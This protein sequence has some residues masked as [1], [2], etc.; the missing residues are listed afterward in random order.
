MY[1]YFISLHTYVRTYMYICIDIYLCMFVCVRAVYKLNIS[2]YVCM[3][4]CVLH[5]L[6]IEIVED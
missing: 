3:Y 2:V 6:E 1:A 5:P 4:K